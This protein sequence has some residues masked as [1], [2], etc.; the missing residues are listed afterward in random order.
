M[1][2]N[3]DIMDRIIA[4]QVWLQRYSTSTVRKIIGLLNLSDRRIV[5]RLAAQDMTD[6]SRGRQET[7]LKSIRTI[8]AGAYGKAV[9]ALTSELASFAGYEAGY[10]ADMLARALP[11]VIDTVRPGP[12]QVVASAKARPFQGR[13]L[14]EWGADLEETAFK[15]VRDTIRTGVLEGRTT[16]Q[17]VR[18]IRGTRA[19][20]YAD[21]ILERNRREVE[22]VV[23]TAVN[24]TS[25]VARNET[26]AANKD[27]LKGV[28]WVST[29]DSRTTPVCAARDGTVYPVDSGPRPPA[30]FGCRSTTT[31]VTKSWRELGFDIDDLPPGTRASINGQVPAD[32]TYAAW[33]KRQ[34]VAVQEE[35]LGVTKAKLFRNGDLPLDRF[36]DTKGDAYTL[37][38]LKRRDRGA[39]EKAGLL[40]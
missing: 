33:L 37:E 34:P 11:P 28:R 7:L 38:D 6:L 39:F 40:D 29:L 26:Y 8:M 18:D 13:L 17:I 4:H 12:A 22:S 32:T 24:H 21:G 30:H 23:R 3:D 15:R 2:V 5:E 14:S 25:Q 9:G 27:L 19:R 20:K 35:V 1:S 10:A 16:D 31:P 36:V